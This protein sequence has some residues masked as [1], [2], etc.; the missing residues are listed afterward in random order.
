MPITFKTINDTCPYCGKI[1]SKDEIGTTAGY[2]ASKRKSIT[3]FHIECFDKNIKR[4]RKDT[5]SLYQ[6]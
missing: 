6:N 5:C 1:I 2:A 3:Y 4:G